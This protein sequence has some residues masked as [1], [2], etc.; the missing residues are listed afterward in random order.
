MISVM[1]NEIETAEFH[2]QSQAHSYDSL[3]YIAGFVIPVPRNNI[4][5]YRRIAQKAG[6]VWRDHGALGIL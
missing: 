3:Y 5:D 4:N 2:K 6:E 1:T